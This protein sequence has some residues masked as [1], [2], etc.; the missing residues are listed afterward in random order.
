MRDH[1]SASV[2]GFI[3]AGDFARRVGVTKPTVNRWV[4]LGLLPA[5]RLG[6]RVLIPSDALQRLLQRQR[7][8]ADASESA[9]TTT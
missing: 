4:R 7:S 5:V 3:R 9:I 8:Q 2:D 6:R 1:E